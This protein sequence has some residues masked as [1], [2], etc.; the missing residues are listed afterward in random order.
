MPFPYSAK[1][2]M[3][4]STHPFYVE[5]DTAQLAVDAEATD[6]GEDCPRC[7]GW[8]RTLGQMGRLCWFRCV[9]CGMDFSLTLTEAAWENTPDAVEC[10]W[11][12]ADECAMAAERSV[13]GISDVMPTCSVHGAS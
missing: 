9:D 11:T 10:A 6:D 13:A 12:S 8:G 2:T 1:D 5:L 4:D 7:D 3:P